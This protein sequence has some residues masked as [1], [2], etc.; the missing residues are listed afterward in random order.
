MTKGSLSRRLVLL[1]ALLLLGW[2]A[3]VAALA[4]RVATQHEH[5]A[6]Q[7]LSYGL[8]AHIAQH[9]PELGGGSP[10]DPTARQEL[11]RML[12]T[13]NPGIQVYVL[14][15]AGRVQNYIG[16]PGMVRQHQVDKTALKLFLGGAPLPL[17][18]TDPMGG[19]V[20]RLFSVAMFPA[21]A[22]SAGYLYIVLDG[23][24]RSAV[25]SRLSQEPIWRGVAW[26]ALG[27]LLVT[28]LVGALAVRA[29][30]RPLQRLAAAMGQLDLH[31]PSRAG[32]PWPA[33][34]LAVPA[35]PAAADEVSALSHSFQAMAQRLSL[36]HDQQQ[37]HAAAHREVIANVAHDLR[38]P[39]TALHGH[40]EALRAGAGNPQ[41]AA[42][43]VDTAL[44]QSDK[45][46]RLT[47]QLFELAT[48]QSME[49]V[50]H[51]ERFRLDEL[52]ADAVQ[53]FGLLMPAGRVTLAGQPPGAVELD[54]DL[55]L[56][57]RALTNLIDNAVRHSPAAQAVQVSM[58][59]SEAEVAVLVEDSGPGLPQQLQQ[60][61]DAGDSVRDPALR[62]HTGGGMGGLGLAIAQRIA[63][64]HGGRL[65]TLPAPQGGTRLCLAL[66][67]RA[68]SSE[69]VA[70]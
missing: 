13:V 11:L 20:N 22:G 26:A 35:A 68:V 31:Q 52:V 5:E 18:G 36:Q 23:A 1:L 44:A 59:C 42:Q 60:R 55:H 58:R 38:T 29:L 25:A 14:D 43:H 10:D 69:P 47:Q 57:E 50:L 33:S 62:R 7:R 46:R 6:L 54:G 56:I 28:V 30:T 37:R 15:P 45:L 34:D 3:L 12:M 61:L 17:Y 24:A 9:W 51:S 4:W 70:A 41:Q 49:Q 64:L 65:H 8:A 32:P 27:G 19:N 67:R 39:L 48:L 16:E 66:P 53:K 2:G 40:L 21:P 63:T